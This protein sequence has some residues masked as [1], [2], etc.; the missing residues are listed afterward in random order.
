MKFETIENIQSSGFKACIVMSGGG[1]SAANVLLS[2]AGASRFILDV[3]IPYDQNAFKLYLKDTPDS[4]CSVDTTNRLS[5]QAYLNALS[6][7]NDDVIGVAVTAAIA[8]N[9]VRR[10]ADRAYISITSGKGVQCVEVAFKTEG[11]TDQ[12]AELCECIIHFIAKTL[13]V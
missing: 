12:E 1:I 4:F 10:G 8:T 13:K 2:H 6:L 5:R 7:S 3:Q 11:R 9:R